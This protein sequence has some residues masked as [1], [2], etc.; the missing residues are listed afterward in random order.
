VSRYKSYAKRIAREQRR[1]DQGRDNG[2]D[3]SN[4]SSA[5]LETV[6]LSWAEVTAL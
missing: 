1:S 4:S 6:S 2:D 5:V 3:K